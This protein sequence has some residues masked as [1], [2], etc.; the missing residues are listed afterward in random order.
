MQKIVVI[1]TGGMAK[2]VL[3]V[4]SKLPF[5]VVGLLD[6]DRSLHGK[7]IHN[8]PVIGDLSKAKDLLLQ[9]V[10]NAAI[11]I[12]DN[13]IRMQIS[14][15]CK[16]VFK[17]PSLVDPSV[18]IPKDTKIEQ[19][20]IIC[21][22]SVIGPDVVIKE[23]TILNLNSVIG[24]SSTIEHFCNLGVGVK[25]AGRNLIKPYASIG[26]GAIITAGK[27]VIGSIKP[28]AVI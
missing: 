26:T 23:G 21:Q 28:G 10:K 6:H 24:H 14:E 18:Y 5:Q 3:E 15:E 2:L 13:K 4:I 20:C 25:L 7:T 9:D 19:G 8:L 17:F 11:A 12:G 16:G 1:G 27:E 22:G